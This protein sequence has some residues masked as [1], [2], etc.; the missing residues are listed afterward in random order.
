MSQTEQSFFTNVHVSV[1]N[2]L[3]CRDRKL[4][5]SL[6][7][8]LPSV[9]VEI[10]DARLSVVTFFTRCFSVYPAMGSL[11]IEVSLEF[12]ELSFQVNSVPEKHLIQIFSSDGADESFN[13]GM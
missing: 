12:A 1:A 13:E 2:W 5:K 3:L 10:S 8:F 7:M 6:A 4:I 11:L 9:V